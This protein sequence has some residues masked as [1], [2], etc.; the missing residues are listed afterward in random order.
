[1]RIGF[2]SALD[3][4]TQF[5]DLNG[6]GLVQTFKNAGGNSKY[7][8][9]K[10]VTKFKQLGKKRYDLILVD[11]KYD[12]VKY[13]WTFQNDFDVGMLIV[14]GK[15]IANVV[16]IK[17][18]RPM[19]KKGAQKDY[20]FNEML[21]FSKRST[22]I[23]S[24]MTFSNLLKCFL[25]SDYSVT[26][27]LMSIKLLKHYIHNVHNGEEPFVPGPSLASVGGEGLER[28]TAA[29]VRL[30]LMLRMGFWEHRL[31]N[32][33]F[34]P[35]DAFHE[36][37]FYFA[38]DPY[39]NTAK[40]KA[41]LAP[42]ITSFGCSTSSGIYP[43]FVISSA[44]NASVR[45]NGY[46]PTEVSTNDDW[47]IQFYGKDFDNAIKEMIELGLVKF[48]K[49]C[50]SVRTIKVDKDSV[51]KFSF[52]RSI[53]ESAAGFTRSM[54]VNG[55]NTVKKVVDIKVPDD[56]PFGKYIYQ[57]WYNAVKNGIA[58]RVIGSYDDWLISTLKSVTTASSGMPDPVKATFKVNGDYS[59]V[60]RSV[61]KTR[62][63]GS[64][65]TL[66]TRTMNDKAFQMLNDPWRLVNP[67]LITAP[68]KMDTIHI[69]KSGNTIQ[70]VKTHAGSVAVRWVKIKASRFIYANN[71]PKILGEDVFAKGLVEEQNYYPKKLDGSIDFSKTWND[72]SYIY[73]V[74]KQKS[75]LVDAMRGL[76]ES[77]NSDTFIAGFDYSSF[78]LTQQFMN[79]RRYE[80]AA[81]KKAFTDSG[82]DGP[83][84]PKD[85]N[86]NFIDKYTFYK[87]VSEVVDAV[88]GEGSGYNAEFLVSS[89]TTAGRHVVKLFISWRKSGE[90][91][92][93]NA[94][95]IVNYANIKTFFDILNS[96]EDLKG[97]NF[98]WVEIMGD[99][100]VMTIYI[101]P[102][103]RNYNKISTLIKEYVDITNKNGMEINPTKTEAGF[104][105]YSYLQVICW[106][107][108]LIPKV[109]TDLL[110]T[111]HPGSA[112][113]V[114]TMQALM[115]LKTTLSVLAARGMP[116][117]F[118]D[119]YFTNIFVWRAKDI[120]R[121]EKGNLNYW[122]PI[123]SAFIPRELGGLGDGLFL[124]GSNNEF[125]LKI[126]L[127]NIDDINLRKH[128]HQLAYV[129]STPSDNVRR[130]VARNLTNSGFGASAKQYF[131]SISDKN[132]IFKSKQAYNILKKRG[133]D[134]PENYLPSRWADSTVN[135]FIVENNKIRELDLVT[136]INRLPDLIERATKPSEINFLDDIT[137]TI[138]F[139][140]ADYM[141]KHESINPV[142]T[143]LCFLTGI[144]ERMLFY[145]GID[146][147]N[148]DSLFSIRSAIESILSSPFVV[149]MKEQELL[150]LLSK[151]SVFLSADNM[152]LILRALGVSEERIVRAVAVLTSQMRL[153]RFQA[154]ANGAST[155]GEMIS[156]L[157]FRSND[158]ES[159]M[160]CDVV[161]GNNTFDLF[162]KQNCYIATL[163]LNYYNRNQ[164]FVKYRFTFDR[165]FIVKLYKD[166]LQ[167]PNSAKV[168]ELT[169]P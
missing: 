22:P 113:T 85:K 97:F 110:G 4:T 56:P 31:L 20:M 154:N 123:T 7:D 30:G 94:N 152:S 127:N 144:G 106:Y 70:E 69:Y 32:D 51:K 60:H 11:V 103:D 80:I 83:F 104:H 130:E 81:I 82:V 121:T 93:L 155:G 90:K 132:L 68:Y 89:P 64:K 138:H 139:K 5:K 107:G 43:K 45:F 23:G 42:I 136:K 99:D 119:K 168:M 48:A 137:S 100:S 111:E 38:Q 74:G 16:D 166:L 131:T 21:Y 25:L 145:Y 105:Y 91:T 122:Y 47:K 37:L 163:I 115:A 162:M 140:A 158:F 169:L 65:Y 72:S 116:Y 86:G 63:D 13:V 33:P 156:Y 73:S 19:S 146:S 27:N 15:Q 167:Q 28:D 41:L 6:L 1:V 117:E 165:D 75:T 141:S 160:Y 148:G 92:T 135:R 57:L 14:N 88:Y 24:S 40:L 149:R 39:E 8:K 29:V 109:A 157:S 78:D 58:K 153:L 9:I 164:I 18:V 44:S 101:N 124:L 77:S 2:E 34:I 143:P 26:I 71:H 147:E 120:A 62:Q 150:K 96:R 151:P 134:F 54:E 129:L 10:R 161:T 108:M 128:L 49:M 98:K 67:A 46:V 52:L 36:L 95:N 126:I 61:L 102:Q 159:G 142:I 76:Q 12:D 125:A 112:T 79:T 66:I 87:G 114:D 17:W 35:M 59:I 3:A 50:S 53:C 84:G 133:I 118:L 55:L